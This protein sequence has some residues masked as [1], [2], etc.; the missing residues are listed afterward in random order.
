MKNTQVK[1]ATRNIRKR[2]VSYLSICLV[3]MLGVGAFL[4]TSYM[5]A[6]I[7]RE[8]SGYFIDHGFKDF[9]LISSLG[10]SEANIEV[11]RN[12]DGVSDAEGVMEFEGSLQTGDTKSSV[13]VLSMTER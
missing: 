2:I 1:D 7:S 5:E 13:T 8:A 4:A 12:T 9:E 6:G 10:A 3:I 11:I